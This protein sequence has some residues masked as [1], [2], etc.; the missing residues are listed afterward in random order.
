VQERGEV[1]EKLEGVVEKLDEANDQLIIVN[2]K[3]DDV[4]LARRI[5][6]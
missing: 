6:L 4:E 3:L 2:E 1:I 5:H